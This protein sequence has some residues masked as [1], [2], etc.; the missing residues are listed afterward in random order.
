MA[1][2]SASIS[3]DV[4]FVSDEEIA[5]LNADYRGKPRPTDVLSFAQ[6]ESA[7]ESDAFFAPPDAPLMLGDLIVSLETALRQAAEQRHDLESEI[8]F[9]VAHGTLHLIGYDHGKSGARK[10]MFALQDE[11]VEELRVLA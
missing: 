5:K 1:D 7:D 3:V 4:T 2:K 6:S 9:L 8:A 10:I 11:I